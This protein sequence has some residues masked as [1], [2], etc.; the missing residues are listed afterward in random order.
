M[1]MFDQQVAAARAIAEQRLH[2]G[3]RL[4]IDLAAL[5]GAAGLAAATRRAIVRGRR[6]I[7]DIHGLLRAPE[8]NPSSLRDNPVRPIGR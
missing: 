8:L 2:V 7:L 1:Q 3:E 5:R 4:R 6:R